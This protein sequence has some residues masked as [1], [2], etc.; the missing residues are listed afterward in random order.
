MP[1][2]CC[3][4]YTGLKD[5]QTFLSDVKAYCDCIHEASASHLC[6]VCDGGFEFDQ[7]KCVL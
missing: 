2:L 3:G 5:K 1:G 4:E 6:H 7:D